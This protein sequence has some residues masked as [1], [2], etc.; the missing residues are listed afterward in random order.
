MRATSAFTRCVAPSAH[1]S[2]VLYRVLAESDAGVASSPLALDPGV[3]AVYEN[4][5]YYVND[6]Q[7]DSVLP[8]YHVLVPGVDP[9]DPQVELISDVEV[10]R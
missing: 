1:N 4:W 7:V 3:F 10:S 8:V 5:G 6:N 9:T 2:E